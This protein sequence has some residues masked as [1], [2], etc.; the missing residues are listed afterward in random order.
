MA[1]DKK[2]SKKSY[3]NGKKTVNREPLTMNREP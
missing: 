2:Y 3:V 1:Y